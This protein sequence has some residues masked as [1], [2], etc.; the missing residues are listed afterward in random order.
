MKSGQQLNRSIVCCL[1]VSLLGLAGCATS[2]RR[3]YS[4]EPR[5]IKDIAI[6]VATSPC[7]IDSIATVGKPKMNLSGDG[8]LLGELLPGNYVLEVRYYQEVVGYKSTEKSW[9]KSVSLPLRAEPGHVYYIYPEVPTADVWRPSVIDI[10]HDE[11]Y[12]KMEG[13]GH[14][15]SKFREMITNYVIGDR[16]VIQKVEFTTR[17][18]EHL[19]LWR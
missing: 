17:D 8:Y 5:A 16:Q 1:I 9:G 12:N 11:D 6:V 14:S 3:F 7:R 2:G 10:A 4:E 19:T 15:P 18:G 13:I